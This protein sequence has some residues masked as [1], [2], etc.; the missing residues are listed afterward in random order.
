MVEPI[1]AWE[2]V[3]ALKPFIHQTVDEVL[4]KMIAKGC[5]EP[6]DLVAEF[7]LPIPSY[8]GCSILSKDVL[9]TL[10]RFRS[11]IQFLEFHSKI[12]ST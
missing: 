12:F 9:E 11:S 5:A 7:A 4:S 3:L 8:V 1:F 10:N 2:Q 6:V